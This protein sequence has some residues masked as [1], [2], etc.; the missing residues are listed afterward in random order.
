MAMTRKTIITALIFLLIQTGMNA[1]TECQLKITWSMN[2]TNPP[3]YNFTSDYAGDSARFYWHIS[4]EAVYDVPAPTHTFKVSGNHKVLLKVAARDGSVCYGEVS[5]Y[6]EGKD[7]ITTEP[8][9]LQAKGWVKD[10]S[11]ISG[12]RLAISTENGQMLLPVEMLPK[13]ALQPGQYIEFAYE[14]LDNIYTICM[15]GKPVRIHRIA[16]ITP[17][18]AQYITAMGK[19]VD[20]SEMAGC[21]LVIRMDTGTTVI[22]VEIVQNFILKA[23]QYVKFTYEVLDRASACNMGPVVRIHRITVISDTQPECKVE[24]V[25]KVMDAQKFVYKFFARTSSPAEIWDW[26]FGDGSSSNEAEPGHQYEKAGIYE[27]ICTILTESG[28]KVSGRLI[29]YAEAPALPVCPGGISLTLFDPS[30]K[31]CDGKAIAALFDQ[32]GTEYKDVIYRWS[33]GEM[34]NTAQGLCANKPYFIHAYIENVCQKNASFTILSKPTWRVSSSGDLYTFEVENPVEGAVYTW[35]FEDGEEAVG[36]KVT[37]RFGKEGLYNVNLTVS[38]GSM[39]AITDQKVNVTGLTTGLEVIHNQE[40]KIYPNP[41]KEKIYI[42]TGDIRSD[43]INLEVYDI[44]GRILMNRKLEI[45]GKE[46]TEADIQFLPS[47]LYL[48]RLYSAT[49]SWPATRLQVID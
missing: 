3:S 25:Y 9:I 26:Q 39:V 23:G 44:H 16:E 1:Q 22:P 14:Y 27:V 32:N 29:L 35:K 34:G 48:V 17:P 45:S 42:E 13:F 5:G 7:S 38:F 24:P 33:T 30:E 37:F 10:I 49:R 28:C 11:S 41:A 21:D 47:G 40:Y 8:Q 20:M 15:T 6:F 31:G 43:F 2:K 46:R 12:C 36:E 18:P 4:D 19:V